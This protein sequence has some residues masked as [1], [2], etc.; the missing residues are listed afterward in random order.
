MSMRTEPAMTRRRCGVLLVF[1]VTLVADRM[2][3]RESRTSRSDP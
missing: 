2:P 1:G 3:V